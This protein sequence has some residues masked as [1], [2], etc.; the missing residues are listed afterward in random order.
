[1]FLGTLLLKDI[2]MQGRSEEPASTAVP[3]AEQAKEAT[4]Q[5]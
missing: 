1:M 3:E 5:G 4:L 2:P